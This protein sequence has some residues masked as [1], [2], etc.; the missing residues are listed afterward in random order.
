[1]DG[2]RRARQGIDELIAG[3]LIDSACPC[4]AKFELP[5]KLKLNVGFGHRASIE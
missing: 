2:S 1:M 5:L 3:P 4:T